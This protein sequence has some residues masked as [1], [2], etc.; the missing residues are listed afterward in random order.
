MA[1]RTERVLHSGRDPLDSVAAS[2]L[3]QLLRKHGLGA[4]SALHSEVSRF[5]INTLDTTGVA[6]I[7]ITYAE[8]RGE[9][10]HM[11]YLLRRIRQRF[12]LCPVLVGFWDP[13]EHCSGIRQRKKWR[14]P[15]H[16]RAHSTTP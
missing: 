1:H 7:F 5:A 4:Q 14:A 13:D 12:P 16:S 15:P 8:L 10:P 9:P 2:M 3:A 11:R 6:M